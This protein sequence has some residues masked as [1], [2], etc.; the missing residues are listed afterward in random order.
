MRFD[1]AVIHLLL[2][3]AAIGAASAESPARKRSLRAPAGAQAEAGAPVAVAATAVEGDARAA[4]M[5]PQEEEDIRLLAIDD[6]KY[7]KRFLDGD[8]GSLG[9]NPGCSF[10]VSFVIHVVLDMYVFPLK[11]HNLLTYFFCIHS[12]PTYFTTQV[13][14]HC[15]IK[16]AG[17]SRFRDCDDAFVCASDITEQRFEYLGGS[18]NDDPTG[19][20]NYECKTYKEPGID[21]K[22]RILVV[23]GDFWDT[24]TRSD[25]PT[26]QM[27][28]K[29]LNDKTDDKFDLIKIVD[30]DDVEPWDTYSLKDLG[31]R[32][33]TPD[34]VDTE[35]LTYVV[36]EDGN[37]GALLLKATWQWE[38]NG[39]NAGR[40]AIFDNFG[41]S[42]LI[43]FKSKQYGYAEVRGSDPPGNP[44]APPAQVKL[45]TTL[46]NHCDADGMVAHLDRRFCYR[47]VGDTSY[48]CSGSDFGPPLDQ[49]PKLC[50]DEGQ[51]ATDA[52]CDAN[53]PMKDEGTMNVPFVIP[54]GGDITF[55]DEMYTQVVVLQGREYQYRVPNATVY[56][57]NFK[58]D[59]KEFISNLNTQE[60]WFFGEYDPNVPDPA[61]VDCDFEVSFV[62][63]YL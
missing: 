36:F 3:A 51:F 15:A 38:C 59:D 47:D 62:I 25:A 50:V 43:A 34:N 23:Y 19:A 17:G 54:K 44:T 22:V 16:F 52:Q 6:A 40:Y 60:E 7:W 41:S 32:L 37:D 10:D 53:G 8:E 4:I 35:D 33:G 21:E 11:Y 30:I 31:D 28:K 29:E 18:C 26:Y 63:I 1:A 46:K 49:D 13:D 12:Y 9:P 27:A 61:P 5:T 39:S 24:I 20:R 48:K 55:E 42:S 56:F 2:S 14:I 45:T 58:N 57:K